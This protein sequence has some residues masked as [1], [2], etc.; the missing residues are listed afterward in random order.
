ME[1]HSRRVDP[2]NPLSNEQALMLKGA[3]DFSDKVLMGVMVTDGYGV[4]LLVVINGY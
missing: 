3:L 4:W 1:M 2:E